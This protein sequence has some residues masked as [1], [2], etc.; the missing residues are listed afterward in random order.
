MTATMQDHAEPTT[1]VVCEVTVGQLRDLVSGLAADTPL[2]LGVEDRHHVNTLLGTL[3]V[4]A[5]RVSSGAHGAV[6]VFYVPG[7]S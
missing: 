4:T 3:P 7:V 2:S 1:R 5:V 6:L